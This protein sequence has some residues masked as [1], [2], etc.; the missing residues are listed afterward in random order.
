MVLEAGGRCSL[1]LAQPGQRLTAYP[2][3]T[4]HQTWGPNHSVPWTSSGPV[5]GRCFAASPPPSSARGW[6]VIRSGLGS[7]SSSGPSLTL[8]TPSV[9]WAYWDWPHSPKGW[10]KAPVQS[11]TTH[12]RALSAGD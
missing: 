5:S 7:S 9:R 4:L 11:G 12:E 1:A 6:K 3:V 2:G 10:R 8:V